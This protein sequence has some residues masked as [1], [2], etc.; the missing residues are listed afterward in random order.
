M[1]SDSGQSMRDVSL[2]QTFGRAAG[3]YPPPKPRWQF[4]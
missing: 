2:T 3:D 1:C 4:P